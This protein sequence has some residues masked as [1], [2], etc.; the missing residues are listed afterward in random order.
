MNAG[1]TAGHARLTICLAVHDGMPYLPAAVASILGQSLAAF[2]FLVV[3]D[4][5][6]DG[7]ADFLASLGDPRIEVIT[8]PH[9]G[10]SA[11]LNRGIAAA[12][13][14]LIARMDADD[15]ALPERLA[16]Q[17]AF[18]DAHPEVVACGTAIEYFVDGGVRTLP[19]S[20]PLSH[21]Q[22]TRALAEGAHAFCHPTLVF[23]TAA[24][25]NVGGYRETGPGQLSAFA[26]ALARTG[27]LANLDRVLLRKRVWPG[28][29][30]WSHA[31]DV[32]IADY[33]ARRRSSPVPGAAAGERIGAVPSDVRRRLAREVR[34]QLAY[35]R[36]LVAYLRGRPA[37]A[38]WHA[39]AAA[40]WDP[41]RATRRLFDR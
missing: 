20:L 40:L 37:A 19:R 22:V 41:L 17:V 38:A 36:A 25:R 6:G 34:S 32:A 3:D 35:R 2:R 28:S 4:G 5:S 7:S 21:A 10:L 8:Q 11:A 33:L 29:V 9:A 39:L 18:M 23:R 1:V 31:G 12:D 15:V 16:E 26:L 27:K 24:A 13:T 14:E 30:G